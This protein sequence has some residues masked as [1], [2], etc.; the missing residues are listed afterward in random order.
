MKS[1]LNV[2][3]KTAYFYTLLYF[4][5]I[6]LSLT[7]L[8]PYANQKYHKWIISNST[9][10]GKK[11]TYKSNMGIAYMI[12]FTGIAFVITVFSLI[13]FLNALFKVFNFFDY[14]NRF[15]NIVSSNY[16]TIFNVLIILSINIRLFNYKIK[17]THF[18]DDNRKSYMKMAPAYSLISSV[19]TKVITLGTAFFGYPFVVVIKEKF[20]NKRKHICETKCKF[21]GKILPIIKIMYL[22]LLLSVITLLLYVPYLYFKVTKY[23]IENTHLNDEILEIDMEE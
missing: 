13:T 1:S 4:L 23:I 5:A 7:L 11:L 22:G 21:K 12:Y 15:F 18:L 6:I 9:I 16:G 2:K 3:K 19:L 17:C 20:I 14:T 10:D 8:Y